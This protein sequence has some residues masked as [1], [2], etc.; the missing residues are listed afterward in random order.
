MP[1]LF[2]LGISDILEDADAMNVIIFT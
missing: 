2:T 1:N